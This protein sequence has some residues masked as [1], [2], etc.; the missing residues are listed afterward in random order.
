LARLTP[1]FALA[2]AA[3]FFFLPAFVAISILPSV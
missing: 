2:R 1:R 3:D